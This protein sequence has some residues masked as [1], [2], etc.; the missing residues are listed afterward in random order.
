MYLYKKD[1]SMQT[2]TTIGFGDIPFQNFAQRNISI[3]VMIL[4]TI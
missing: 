2:I 4:G 3:L 1:W